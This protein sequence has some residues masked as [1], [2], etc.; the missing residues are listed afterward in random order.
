MI[1]RY[2]CWNVD[3]NIH[4]SSQDTAGDEIVE[5]PYVLASDYAALEARIAQLE[6]ALQLIGNEYDLHSAYGPAGDMF[7]ALLCHTLETVTK[8]ERLL[9]T[10]CWKCALGY[11]AAAPSCPHCGATNANIDLDK[12]ALE[13]G[14]QANRGTKP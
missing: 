8:P 3:C 14:P 2:T 5:G 7:R 11:N 10:K 1:K 6:A 13:A 12:A 9:N 4:D